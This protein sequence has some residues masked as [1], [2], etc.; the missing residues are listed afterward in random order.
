MRI[1]ILADIHGEV[2]NLRNALMVL[3]RHRVDKI[4]VL[5]DVIESTRNAAETVSLLRAHNVDGVWGNHELGLCLEP[6]PEM[7]VQYSEPVVDFFSSLRARFELNDLLFSHNIP[8]R[9]PSNPEIYYVGAEP[10]EEG[11]LQES[12]DAFRHRI[13]FIGH[14]HRWLA[15]T[16]RGC[17]PWDGSTPI[18]LESGKR[19]LIV[20]HA[21]ADGHCAVFD[22]ATDRLT[23]CVL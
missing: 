6:S 8:S 20:V 2:A 10:H 1:G 12:F 22:C 11:A 3:H 18:E 13:M 14:F 17:L 7:R 16:P 5:G 23:P 4:I 9:D 15:A 19:Y 21:V